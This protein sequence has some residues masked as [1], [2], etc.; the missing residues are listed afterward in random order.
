MDVSNV[1][2]RPPDDAAFQIAERAEF[3]G[4]PGEAGKLA[5]VAERHRPAVID[6]FE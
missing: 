2:S 1:D 4:R 5:P 6:R 3:G